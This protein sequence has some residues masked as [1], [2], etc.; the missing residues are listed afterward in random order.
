MVEVAL[1]ELEGVV[2]ETRELRERAA[3]DAVAAL[4]FDENTS[5]DA[6]MRD[7]L[8]LGAE[9]AFSERLATG[10][11]SL[12]PGARAFLEDA[13]A[14]ARLGVVTRAKR[15]DADL[16]LRLAGLES[17]FAV[18]VCADDVLDAKPAP[19]GYHLALDRMMRRRP[20]SRVGAIALESGDAGIGAAR[21]AQMRCVAVGSVPAHVAIEADAFVPTLDGQSLARLDQLSRPGQER[22]R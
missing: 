17:I 22:V 21:A 5:L 18:V 6:V 1:I 8:A 13:A 14:A 4:G 19:D 15:A 20:F 3:R 2:F 9:R 16:M 7:L 12:A 10:G 11:L